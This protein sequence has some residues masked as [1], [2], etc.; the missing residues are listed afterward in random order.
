MLILFFYVFSSLIVIYLINNFVNL[1]ASFSFLKKGFKLKKAEHQ[2]KI[3][4]DNF[5]IV[6]LI[7]VLREQDIITN[8]LKIFTR[9]QGKPEII[10]ITTEKEKYDKIANLEIL[11]SLKEIIL[12]TQTKNIFIEILV[13][14]FPRNKILNIYNA[15]KNFDN[16]EKY[17]DY[18]LKEYDQLKSTKQILI[19]Y[20]KNNKIRCKNVR[21][22]NYP[23]K[24]GLMAH[25]LNYACNQLLHTTNPEKTF[26]LVYNADSTIEPNILEIFS[27]KIKSGERVI[28]QSSLFLTNY[29]SFSKKYRGLILKCIALAQSRWTLIHEIS[30]IRNQYKQN[31]QHFYESA[32]VVGHGTC[33]RL[34]T[35]MSVGGFPSK[36]TNEDLALGYFLALKGERICPVTVLENAESPSSI[37]SVITQYTTWFYGA[38]DYFAYCK[39]AINALS[40][41]KH[42]AIVWAIINSTRALMWL[43]AP[44]TWL[45]LIITPFFLGKPYFSLFFFIIFFIYTTFVYWL[46]IKFISNN[47]YIL[48]KKITYIKFEIGL[49][50]ATPI[51]Y[52]IW[53]IGPTVSAIKKIKAIL[54]NKKIQKKKTER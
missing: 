22:I 46:I 8:C 3:V 5:R 44:W 32:H 49:I 36:F 28:L 52:I 2:N 6:I 1:Q 16:A 19:N 31:W 24:D 29:T 27:T 53:G 39:Y 21:L 18:I 10:Y 25:Q 37:L 11:K 17:W 20:L 43:L 42:K 33:V 4:C 26:I 48:G 54:S 35:L 15:R 12:K 7:P 34:D 40:L 45:A 38:V 13:G 14:Y 51:A 23:Y 30:R 50:I 9:L 47:P 41:P